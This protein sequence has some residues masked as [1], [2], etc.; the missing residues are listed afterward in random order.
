MSTI[1]DVTVPDIGDFKNIPVIEILVKPGDSVAADTPLLT[2]ESE[3]ATLEVPAPFAGTVV[4]LLVAVGG[5]VSEGT[6]IARIEAAATEQ[7]S[8]ALPVPG[9]Q[10][11]EEPPPAIA[12]SAG[13]AAEAV[14]PP[15]LPALSLEGESAPAH[16]SPSV[17]QFARELGIEI[18]LVNGSGPKGRILREDL[19]GFVK[20]RSATASEGTGAV[21]PNLP[22]WPQVDFAKFGAIERVPL[23]RL[24]RISGPNL[25]RNWVTIPHVTNFDEADV[26]D[27]EAFRLKINR[28]GAQGDAKVTMLAFLLKAATVSLKAFP[29]FNASLDGED[30]ILKR[31]Y[32]LGFAADTP[33]GLVVPVIR[34]AN[35]KGIRDIAREMAVLAEQARQGKLKPTDMQGGCF[36]I[37][38]LGGIGGTGFTPIINAP[39]VAI[40]GA[41]RA[42]TK[43]LWDGAQFQPR[44]SLPLSLSWDH[45]VLDGAAAGRFLNHLCGLMSDFRR[46]LL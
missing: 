24:R 15:N 43:P 19:L 12:A 33:N 18:G 2:L 44:L 22:P 1:K 29:E 39:E 37:S 38:S 41:A 16:A 31:Y 21:G 30:L 36:S 46:I 10:L 32:H 7:P 26:T 6:R 28:E 17:R 3:K 4:E 8:Q 5:T 25:A 40:L 13:S 45:R 27:L 34:D 42:R 11:I 20:S 14:P 35:R 23:S 9:D